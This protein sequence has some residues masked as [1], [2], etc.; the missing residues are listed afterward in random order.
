MNHEQ[1]LLIT[2]AKNILCKDNLI[3][4]NEMIKDLDWEKILQISVRHKVLPIVYK[5]IY[6]YIPIKYQASYDQKYYDIIKKVNIRMHELDRILQITK[7]NS[8]DVILL[9][10]PVL[11]DIIYNDLYARQFADLDLLVKKNDMEK[12]FYLLNDIGFMQETGFDENTKRFHTIDKPIFKYGDTFHEFQCVKDI[13]DNIY[14]YVEIKR[15]SSAIPLKHIDDFHKNVQNININGIDVKTSNLKYTFLHLCSNFFTN[16]E[17][18]W[19]INH[20]TNLRDIIDIYMFIS[21]HYNLLN[22]DEINKLS[23][24]YEIAHRIYYAI[25]CLSKFYNDIIPNDIS[26]LFNPNRVLY[27][28]NG[29]DD[30]SINRW[31]S[32]FI[33]RLFNDEDRKQQFVKMNKLKTYNVNNYNNHDKVEKE[34]FITVTNNELFRYFNIESLQWNVKYVFTC[35]SKSLYLYLVI[36][37]KVYEQLSEYNLLI[38]FIDNNLDNSIPNRIITITI[39]DSFQVKFTNLQQCSWKLFELGNERLIKM[40]IPFNCLDMN[41]EDSGNRIFHNF[42][43]QEKLGNDGFRSVG[44]KYGPKELTFLRIYE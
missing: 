23:N 3:L 29:N 34:L 13:G 31:D 38:Y 30:G 5:A 12:M 41:F 18:G 24:K 21:K 15:A 33:F 4:N 20:E 10:G 37:N 16:F 43:C 40:F 8:I 32:D 7:Q 25:T 17:T 44:S 11:S 14:I 27:D 36:D 22:W 1:K 42:I 28:L 2:I 9:K 26:E 35:D 6:N 39:D 19:G